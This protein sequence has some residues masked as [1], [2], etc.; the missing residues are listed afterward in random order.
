MVHGT[1]PLLPFDILEATYLSPPQDFRLSTEELIS[2]RAS[3]LA[4]WLEDIKQMWNTVTKFR[5]M[6]LEQFEKR[7]SSRI[8]DFD[9]KPGAL[10]L[11]RNSRVEESLNCTTKPRYTGPMVVVRKTIGTSYIVAELDGAESELQVAGFR[12]IP[13]FPRTVTATPIVPSAPKF[14]DTTMDDPEDV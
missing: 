8:I 6:S 4:K 9:F 10:V 3:Q 1:H 12:L 5:C 11:V 2:L 14:N 13:Y 7:H